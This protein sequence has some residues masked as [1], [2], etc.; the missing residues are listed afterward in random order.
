MKLNGM[1]AGVFAL[2]VAMSSQ[3]AEPWEAFLD[4]VRIKQAIADT[5]TP[6]QLE[7]RKIRLAQFMYQQSLLG[8]GR[9]PGNTCPG[10]VLETTNGPFNDTTVGGVDDYDLPADTTAPTCAAASTCTGAGP[11]GSL[12]RG[13]VYTGT[14]TGPDRAFAIR[15]STACTMTITMDPTGAEDMA[16][17][18]YQSACSS[19]LSDCA[20]VD[21]TG[22]GGGAESVTLDMAAGTDYF[23]VADGYSSGATPPGPAGAYTMTFNGPGCTLVGASTVT[24]TNTAG[25]L[26]FAGSV[27]VATTAQN[28]NV[29]AGGTNTLDLTIQS[30]AFGG[31]N[32]ADF[33]FSPAQSFP[34]NV[35]AG[36]NVN[37]PVVMTASAGGARAATLT[38]QTPNATAPS[39]ASFVVN[40]TGTATADVSPTLTYAPAVATPINFAG[41]APGTANSSIAITAAGAVGAGS[42]SVTAC[43]FAGGTPGA[44]TVAT[45][46][47]NGVFNTATT[48]GSIDLTC[49]RG[50]AATTSTLTCTETSGV[51][52]RG[53]PSSRSWPVNCPAADSPLLS[54]TKT[55]AGSFTPGGAIV[56]TI[57][58]TNTGTGA[59]ADNAGDEFVDVLP[60]QLTLVGANA[61]SGTA[62]AN[63]GTRTVTWNGALAAGA[64]VTITINAT[65]ANTLGTVTNQGTVNFDA[66][67][68]GSNESSATTDD[69]TVG[70]ANNAT[71][72]A[73]GGQLQAIPV[74]NNWS[75]LLAVLAVLTMGLGFWAF[76]AR[77]A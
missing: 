76:R 52:N 68:N 12:P 36:A 27:G 26:N 44:F 4:Q 61:S 47:A 49:T 15:S 21:D 30:C 35:A 64:S 1:L 13:A 5:L 62:L 42:T 70:G 22:V 34:I 16:L 28:V 48:S 3:A 7:A 6:E 53:V 23:V 31:A 57:T 58:I 65:I 29:A 77:S 66:D 19:A 14:G 41:G 33:S 2:T 9:T 45:T 67:G 20:C 75:K 73:I 60:G 56:Y 39:G 32:A 69:P 38:C 54:A 25:P 10:A 24:Y 59:Q 71:T 63:V 8:G 74:L 43:G 11:A 40:L 17:I 50:A 51:A 46:P 37:L 72:F 18:A 55:V